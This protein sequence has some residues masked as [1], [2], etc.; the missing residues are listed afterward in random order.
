MVATIHPVAVVPRLEPKTMP[1]ALAREM[2]PVPTNA[3]TIRLTTE[4]L[5][6]TAVA[7]APD[8]M[9]FTGCEV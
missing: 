4:L 5:C 7:I 2:I 8:K 9:P 3:N 1:I 6:R